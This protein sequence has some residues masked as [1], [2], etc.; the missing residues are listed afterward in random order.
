MNIVLCHESWGRR[1][2]DDTAEMSV[3]ACVFLFLFS[4]RVFKAS[5]FLFLLLTEPTVLSFL[6]LSFDKAL[7][8]GV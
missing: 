5:L 4:K 1:S 7:E 6:S 2:Q 8:F 3:C